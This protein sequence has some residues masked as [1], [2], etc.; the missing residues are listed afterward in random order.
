MT[1]SHLDSRVHSLLLDLICGKQAEEEFIAELDVIRFSIEIEEFKEGESD[2]EAKFDF[3]FQNKKLIDKNKRLR[4]TFFKHFNI[5]IPED[6]YKKAE[7]IV[8]YP[9]EFYDEELRARIIIE[10]DSKCGLCQNDISNIHPHLHHIDYN[11]KNCSQENLIFLCPRC[12]GKTN[13][14][15]D[16]WEQLLVEKKG[17]IQK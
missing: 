15:R 16:F 4:N 12:H 13:S 17:D 10:Q 7:E 5:S 11:K 3:Y 9:D 8:G 6:F 2:S 14:K 1:Q